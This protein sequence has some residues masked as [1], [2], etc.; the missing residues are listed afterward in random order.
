MEK[1][2]KRGGSLRRDFQ[3]ETG[4]EREP[5]SFESDAQ[6]EGRS[7]QTTVENDEGDAVTLDAY[8]P[9]PACREKEACC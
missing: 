1:A 3:G 9:P 4:K 7:P 8:L 5:A 2:R 6:A